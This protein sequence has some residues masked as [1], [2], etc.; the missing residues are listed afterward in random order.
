MRMLAASG[1]PSRPANRNREGITQRREAS[2]RTKLAK[3]NTWRTKKPPRR[4]GAG[5][6]VLAAASAVGVAALAPSSAA[7]AATA[8]T[9]AG[10][11]SLGITKQF[12]G[13]TTEPYT[14]KVTP[15]Y[16]YTLTNSK[17]MKVQILSY[18][19]ITQAVDVPGKNGKSADVVLGFKTLQ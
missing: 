16:R 8:Q 3:V 9:A 6:L 7:R 17:G 10:H 2:M 5:I 4:T 1:A 11:S 13:S 12:F 18:G 15:T 19:A 14:G